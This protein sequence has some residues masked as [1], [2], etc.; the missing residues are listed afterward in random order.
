MSQKDKLIEYTELFKFFDKDEDGLISIEEFSDL[1]KVCDYNHIESQVPQIVSKI[2]IDKEEEKINF[3][4]LLK[5][6]KHPPEFLSFYDLR[7]ALTYFGDEDGF[8]D[9]NE[10]RECLVKL[11]DK[12]P[13]SEVED[14][15]QNIPKTN[16]K[17]DYNIIYDILT[18]NEE[19]QV[20]EEEEGGKDEKLLFV[21]NEDS[22]IEEI[23]M[24]SS[25]YS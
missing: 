18:L 19:E 24:S 5:F 1:L 12:I 25:K 9:E 16:G 23:E 14:F 22:A 13:K 20:N 4:E 21:Q 8:I 2:K 3:N 17:I 6:F 7:T 15:L 10:F 11:G